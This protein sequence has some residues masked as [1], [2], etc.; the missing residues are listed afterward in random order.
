MKRKETTH[1]KSQII[2]TNNNKRHNRATQSGSKVG[3]NTVERLPIQ[4]ND[5]I[6]G[7]ERGIHSKLSQYVSLESSQNL[8]N[9]KASSRIYSKLPTKRRTVKAPLPMEGETL[10]YQT[11]TDCPLI[12]KEILRQNIRHFK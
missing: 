12:E 9:F 10:E 11:L 5:I 6:G 8:Q 7:P 1:T 4:K 2:Y 3:I